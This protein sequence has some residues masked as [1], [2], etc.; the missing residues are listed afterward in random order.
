MALHPDTQDPELVPYSGLYGSKE[1]MHPAAGP[2]FICEGS[3]LVKEALAAGREGGVRVVSVLALPEAAVSLQPL[4]PEETLMLTAE[5]S[6]LETLLG[7]P[8]HR[9]MLCCVQRPFDPPEEQILSAGK[10][11][12]LP[13]LD[14]VDNLG[15]ILRTAAALGMDAV[16]VGRGP[17]AFE[18]RTVR[19]SM[20]A[21]WRIPVLQRLDLA[22]LVARWRGFDASSE[23]VGA[24]LVEGATNGYHW[25]PGPRTALV[26]G[27]EDRGLDSDWLARCDRHIVIPMARNMDSLNVA[28]A[29]A[30]LMGRMAA[31]D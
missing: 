19:V 2:C 26:L 24:A 6:F 5:A 1:A 3:Y 27:P 25:L 11:I 12:V 16:V 21:A 8:F 29:G 15:Q 31:A 9:G 17:G 7:F 20:G 13:H 4:L 30:I 23:V 22:P 10:L 28:A 14:N 18:R